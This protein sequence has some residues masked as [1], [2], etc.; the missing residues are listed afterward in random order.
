MNVSNRTTAGPR[1]STAKSTGRSAANSLTKRWD[2]LH[3][4]DREPY[5][6]TALVTRLAKKHAAFASWVAAHGGAAPIGAAVQQAWSEFHAGEF[7]SAIEIGDKWGALGAIAANKA[8][9]LYSLSA[10]RSEAR[11]LKLLKASVARA[12]R[13]VEMLPDHA[14]AHYT[15]ALAEGRYSQHTSILQALA[16]G[17]ATRVRAAL[18]RTLELEPGHAEAHVALGLFHAEI[19]SKLGSLVA[20]FTYQ[21]SEKE[22][23]EHFRRALRLAPRSP[24]AHVEYAHGLLLLDATGKRQEALELYAKAADF[25]PADAME[26]LDVERAKRGLG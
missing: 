1:K 13:A 25:D 7:I 18:E 26:R 14:N 22:A 8:A 17:V 4:G 6:D 20:R 21:V 24:V 9:S 3:E 23:V 16:D 10:D 15:L 2:R 5:P 19:V 12:Q 11:A